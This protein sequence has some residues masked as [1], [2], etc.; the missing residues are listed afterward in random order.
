VSSFGNLWQTT[1]QPTGINYT[2]NPGKYTLEV[3]CNPILSSEISFSK[4]FVIIISPPWWQTWW[5]RVVAILLL[6]GFIA[7]IFQQ[8]NHR[9]YINKIRELQTQYEIQRERERISRDLHD[10][11]G[12]QANALLYG[13]EQLQKIQHN[14]KPLVDNLQSTAKDMMQS[15][16]ETVWAMKNASVAAS[17]IWV[18]VI[19][20]CKQ[21]GFF[22]KE[23]KMRIEGD[24]P[25]NLILNSKIALHIVLITQ[26]A[27]NNAIRHAK[28]QNIFVKS[29]EE[30]NIWKIYISDDGQGFDKDT[31]VKT[32]GGGFGL[33]NMQERASMANI[34]L[35]V[36]SKLSKGTVI[37]LLIP[38]N[39]EYLI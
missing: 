25:Q 37:T 35:T 8:Y 2:L 16:R 13:T 10:N 4:K 27:I 26:E 14:E 22:Y 29:E 24:A 11:I 38:I 34:D 31:G 9:K 3:I 32:P 28:A 19:N 6:I 21:L 17:D 15:L 30:N 18:R 33:S 36:E 39:K 12:A 23:I 20:F 1:Y 5:F 7:F